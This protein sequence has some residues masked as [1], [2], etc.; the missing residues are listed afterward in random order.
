MKLYTIG[1]TGKSAERFFGLLENAGVR[2]LVD[3]RLRNTSQLSGFAK[4]SDLK[5]FLRR[6]SGIEYSHHSELAPTD[7]LL[8]GYKKE[9]GTWAEYE[10]KFLELMASRSIESTLVREELRDACLLCSEDKPTECHR[11]LVAEYLK[12]KWGDIEIGHLV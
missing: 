3:V 10:R 12:D 9:K 7:E 8:D 6:V 2:H 11:R 1:F 4:A 5:Y